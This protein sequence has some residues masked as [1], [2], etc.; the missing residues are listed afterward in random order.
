LRIK[1]VYTTYHVINLL[2]CKEFDKANI[3]VVIEKWMSCDALWVLGRKKEEYCLRTRGNEKYS[4]KECKKTM[5]IPTFT[6]ST[7]NIKH[8]T[9]KYKG[10]KG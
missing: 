6:Y 7:F 3:N 9:K 5:L 8:K 4:L 1:N 2:D 10:W